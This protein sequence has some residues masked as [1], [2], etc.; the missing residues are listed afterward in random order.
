MQDHSPQNPIL[1]WDKKENIIDFLFPNVGSNDRKR[2][3]IQVLESMRADLVAFD[4]N[5][6]EAL[7]GNADS[8]NYMEGENGTNIG[9]SLGD[10]SPYSNSFSIQTAM[11]GT[12]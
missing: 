1:L 2:C 3:V 8:I 10:L 11:D 4:F 7:Q 5:L 9:T 12:N 6:F